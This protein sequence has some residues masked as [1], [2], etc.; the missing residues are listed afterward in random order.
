MTFHHVALWRVKNGARRKGNYKGIGINKRKAGGW[1]CVSLLC[2]CGVCVFVYMCVF[3]Y[4]P[5]R[6]HTVFMSSLS[7]LL[8]K[9]GPPSQVFLVYPDLAQHLRSLLFPAHGGKKRRFY[10]PFPSHSLWPPFLPS[11]K[12]MSASISIFAILLVCSL[13]YVIRIFH[14][15]SRVNLFFYLSLEI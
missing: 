13:L 12:S 3:V 8:F 10:A 9:V 6:T 15:F 5:Y 1:W 7:A 14:S 11:C 4:L 2:V